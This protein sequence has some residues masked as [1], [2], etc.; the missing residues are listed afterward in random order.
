MFKKGDRVTISL[1]QND[2][3]VKA[4]LRQFNGRTVRITKVITKGPMPQFCLLGCRSDF[5]KD[6]FFLGEWLTLVGKESE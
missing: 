1:P 3:M 6:Y 4:N 5:G 2:L